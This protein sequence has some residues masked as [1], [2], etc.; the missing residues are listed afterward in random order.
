MLTREINIFFLLVRKPKRS[1]GHNLN[2]P[3]FCNIL[4]KKS[5]RQAGLHKIEKWLGPHQNRLQSA[6]FQMRQ[7]RRI[8]THLHLFIYI[9]ASGPHLW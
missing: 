3:T 1:N 6:F 2:S 8:D 4:L 9:M 7:K 5:L